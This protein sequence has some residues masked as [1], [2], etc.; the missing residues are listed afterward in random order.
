MTI[1]Y[2]GMASVNINVMMQG[3]SIHQEYDL[4]E[5]HAGGRESTL[6]YP[7]LKPSTHS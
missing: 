3:C 2:E 5:S 6:V 7:H 1:R 4:S